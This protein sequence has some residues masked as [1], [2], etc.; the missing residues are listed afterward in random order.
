MHTVHCALG[1]RCGTCV[2]LVF[3]VVTVASD[4]GRNAGDADYAAVLCMTPW[5][6]AAQSLQRLGY[7]LDGPRFKF[8]QQQDIF[9]YSKAPDK[10][11]SPPSLLLND[12]RGTSTE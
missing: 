1:I 10:F 11:W 8:R 6:G 12:Y 9:L 3:G 2:V 7:G 5:S 4:E